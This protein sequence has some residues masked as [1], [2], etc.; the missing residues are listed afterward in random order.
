[1]AWSVESIRVL[2]VVIV[3]GGCQVVTKA[4]GSG[5]K[6][7]SRARE[8]E[9]PVKLFEF[10]LDDGVGRGSAEFAGWG[11]GECSWPGDGDESRADAN[12]G[13]NGPGHFVHDSS[14]FSRVVVRVGLDSDGKTLSLFRRGESYRDGV[15]GPDTVDPSG[16]AFNVGGADVAA[17][18]DDHVLLSAAHNDVACL[19][20]VSE[21]PG[22]KPSV[23]V[24]RIVATDEVDVTSRNGDPADC[25]FADLAVLQC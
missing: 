7:D 23:C 12:L 21:V 11:L 22:C 17:G 5:G 16:G 18:D 10:G 1:M 20:E 4:N 8:V 24:E 15:T 14:L 9:T 25:E 19:G 13:E 6:F 3:G 2:P